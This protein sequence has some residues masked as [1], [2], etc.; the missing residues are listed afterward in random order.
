M[1]RI[2]RTRIFRFKVLVL[3]TMPQAMQTAPLNRPDLDLNPPTEKLQKA[4]QAHRCGK[5]SRWHFVNEF[6]A[7]A[8]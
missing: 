5:L 7:T 3:A 8:F 6:A 1:I 4:N 2:N